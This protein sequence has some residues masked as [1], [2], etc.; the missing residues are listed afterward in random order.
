MLL[1]NA[2]VPLALIPPTRISANSRPPSEKLIVDVG[3]V[4]ASLKNFN[5]PSL[6]SRATPAN[7]RRAD[8]TAVPEPAT[9]TTLAAVLAKVKVVLDGTEVILKVPLKVASTPVTTTT[10]P[11]KKVC[12]VE[13][14][15]VA[16]LFVKALFDTVFVI[17]EIVV[18][19][20]PT[21]ARSTL[22]A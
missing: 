20:S 2:T 13:V 7:L 12:E 8:T 16:T 15:R 3:L 14:V 19:N 5:T 18:A 21:K 9:D 1:D 4:V 17:A 22:S 11:T 10:S 6:A